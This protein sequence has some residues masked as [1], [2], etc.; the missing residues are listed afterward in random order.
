MSLV[1]PPD[2]LAKANVNA[3]FAEIYIQKMG[4]RPR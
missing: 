1:N 3:A 2:P 4:E